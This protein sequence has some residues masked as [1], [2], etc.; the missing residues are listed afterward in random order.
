MVHIDNLDINSLVK[1]VSKTEK[2]IIE[3]NGSLVELLP[4]EQY[5]LCALQDLQNLQSTWCVTPRPISIFFSGRSRLRVNRNVQQEPWF[6]ERMS[7]VKTQVKGKC[8][9]TMGELAREA[10]II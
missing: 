6:S 4:N 7:R 9:R 2:A 3:L 5:V 1:N 10:G 8:H